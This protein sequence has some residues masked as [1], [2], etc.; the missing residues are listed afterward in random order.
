MPEGHT[1]HRLAAE[2]NARF[3]G[4]VTRSSSPQ[5]R[6]AREAAKIDRNMLTKAEA[7]G[8]HL[9][10]GFGE[11]I[12]HV[13]LGLLGKVTFTPPTGASGRGELR[14]AKRTGHRRQAAL[15]CRRRWVHCAG[16]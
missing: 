14:P 16:G 3:Q 10:A 4:R 15:L 11:H 1:L 6:F 9:L 8:K 12:V 13:H 5:G 2:Y 7:Y